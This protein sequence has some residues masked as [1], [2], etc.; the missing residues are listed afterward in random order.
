MSKF[1]RRQNGQIPAEV[2]KIDR[3]RVVPMSETLS[4]ALGW[5]GIEEGMTGPVVLRNPT[6]CKE[7]ARLGA[8]VFSGHWPKDILRHSFGSFRNAVLRNLPEVAE[9]MGTSVAMLHKHYHNPKAEAEGVEW[10]TVPV[11]T[12]SDETWIQ[13]LN[14]CDKEKKQA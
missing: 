3:P 9:E 11:P 8:L 14:R 12:S 6:E 4:K 13:A 2:S 7:T 1:M 10:F 5:A